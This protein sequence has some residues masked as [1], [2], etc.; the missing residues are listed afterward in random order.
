MVLPENRNPFV[1]KLSAMDCVDVLMRF[2]A[3]LLG[4][5]YLLGFF[6]VA[7]LRGDLGLYILIV[8]QIALMFLCA[9]SPARYSRRI[10]IILLILAI[11]AVV[12]FVVRALPALLHRGNYLND[13]VFYSAELIVVIWF[14]AMQFKKGESIGIDKVHNLSQSFTIFHRVRLD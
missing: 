12:D 4:L 14:I 7:S 1:R 13:I 10:L 6:R 9:V 8:S 5:S 3:L 2:V 11:V